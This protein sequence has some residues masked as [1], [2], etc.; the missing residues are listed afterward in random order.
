MAD[1]RQLRKKFRGSL[2]PVA[3]SD[4][5]IS[6]L[7]VFALLDEE[8]VSPAGPKLGRSPKLGASVTAAATV[9]GF[10]KGKRPLLF[11]N[12]RLNGLMYPTTRQWWIA[13]VP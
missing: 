13:L 5:H 12:D 9:T 6:R 3:H 7:V 10:R 2:E 4:Q 1:R 11:T 8:L